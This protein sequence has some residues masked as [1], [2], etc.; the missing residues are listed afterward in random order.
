MRNLA[1]EVAPFIQ[2]N[3]TAQTYVDNQT[4]WPHAYR[5]TE[6]FRQR[7]AEVPAGRLGTGRELAQSVLF[8]AG[9]ES[10]FL[11]GHILPFAGGWIAS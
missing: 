6:E 11:Y 1:L 9:P 8:L 2:V 3:G 7:L 4:Y 5:E 10:D